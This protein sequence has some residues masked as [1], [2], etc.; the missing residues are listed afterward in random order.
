MTQRNTTNWLCCK[1]SEATES[2]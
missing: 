1:S 2:V